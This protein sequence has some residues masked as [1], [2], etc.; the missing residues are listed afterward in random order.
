MSA[1]IATRRPR[2]SQRGVWMGNGKCAVRV[3]RPRPGHP[4]EVVCVGETGVTFLT[5]FA[6]LEAN[7]YH[8]LKHKPRYAGRRQ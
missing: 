4:G 3:L 2:A 5:T 6:K 1:V 7:G 8:L